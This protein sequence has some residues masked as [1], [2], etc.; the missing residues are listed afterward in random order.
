MSDADKVPEKISDKTSDKTP[1]VQGRESR[2]DSSTDAA[3]DTH[4]DGHHSPGVTRKTIGVTVTVTA[5]CLASFLVYEV[6]YLYMRAAWTRDAFVRVDVVEIATEQVSGYVTN[7]AVDIN[8]RV[9]AG[10]LLF[11]I[12]STRYK[13]ELEYAIADLEIA[14]AEAE[15]N[16]AFAA[17]R[18]E[19]GDAVS[20]EDKQQ[21]DMLART[22]LAQVRK[23]QANLDLA[24]YNLYR[25]KVFAQSDGW[26]SNLMLQVGDFARSGDPA[27]ILLNEESY[28]VEAYFEETKLFGVE[29]GSEAA[30]ALMAY[31]EPLRGRVISMSKGIANRNNN[32]GFQGLQDVNPV[33]AWVRLAQRIPVIVQLEEMPKGIPLVA[34]MTA[35]VAVG[36]AAQETLKPTNPFDRLMRWLAF[37]L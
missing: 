15:L 27:M 23:A 8:Q 16:L 19:V 5:L 22:S 24:R 10:D 28:W 30:V 4:A 3:T 32:P 20:V 25:T 37:Y 18:R 13:L 11:E 1:D 31:D 35:S 2:T 7:L 34:G 17:A 14:Q 33:D 6:W 29:V 9:K 12:D 36:E 26:V 21:Y